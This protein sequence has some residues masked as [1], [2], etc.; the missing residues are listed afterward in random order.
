MSFEDSDLGNVAGAEESAIN[1]RD[2]GNNG[3]NGKDEHV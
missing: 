3:Y 1:D 2:F